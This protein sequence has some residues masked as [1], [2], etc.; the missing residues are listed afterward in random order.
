MLD[1]P[2]TIFGIRM[3]A[4]ARVQ[5]NARRLWISLIFNADKG[6]ERKKL[7]TALTSHPITT[8]PGAFVL[9]LCTVN[10]QRGLICQKPNGCRET[11]WT[12]Q[13]ERYN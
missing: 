13:I 1:V 8:Q 4:K 2:E 7:T 12:K 9:L 5:I 6:K 10:V 3:Y 11:I